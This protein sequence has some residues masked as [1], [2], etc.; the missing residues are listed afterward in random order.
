M[1]IVTLLAILI[2][3]NISGCETMGGLGKDIQ[4]LGGSIEKKASDSN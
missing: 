1:K 4:N 2:T 3:L